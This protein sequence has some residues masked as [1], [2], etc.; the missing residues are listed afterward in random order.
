M[1]CYGQIC[2]YKHVGRVC[3]WQCGSVGFVEGNKG[4]E[5]FQ[6]KGN[7]DFIFGTGIQHIFFEVE[8]CC[9]IYLETGNFDCEDI[10]P[11]R[12]LQI[13]HGFSL[14]AVH[15][16]ERCCCLGY[17]IDRMG[18]FTEWDLCHYGEL[19][20]RPP[21]PSPLQSSLCRQ[22]L[23]VRPAWAVQL[24][25]TK[26]ID[27]IKNRSGFDTVAYRTWAMASVCKDCVWLVIHSPGVVVGRY[28]SLSGQ[29]K[30]SLL[31]LGREIQKMAGTLQAS[32]NDIT[33]RGSTDIVAEFFSAW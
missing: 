20:S 26:F 18:F 24:R 22:F 23:W 16:V 1:S 3:V 6:F 7:E 14:L 31:T 21:L 12:Y 25:Y 33:L 10:H 28:A 30:R 17:G 27:G 19:G 15:N 5:D 8:I 11:R 32:K 29:S 2:I 9:F 4:N 13:T